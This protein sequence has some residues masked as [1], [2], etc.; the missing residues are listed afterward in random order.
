MAKPDVSARE[1]ALARLRLERMTAGEHLLLPPTAKE[2]ATAAAAAA[3][4]DDE[5]AAELAALG[6]EAAGCTRCKL[7]STRR[8]VVFGEGDAHAR[9]MF[10]GEGPGADEDASGHPF[11]GRAGKLLDRMIQAMGLAREEV[12][13]ANIV[14]CRP[15]G[16]RTPAP[17]E[18]AACSPYLC[19]QIR[20]IEPKVICALGSP[21]A[22]M[23]LATTAAIGKLRGRFHPIAF[24]RGSTKPL[25]MPTYH[26]AYLLRTP[27]DKPKVWEDLKQVLAEL[28]L[29][30]PER[31]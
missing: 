12:Y 30:V 20:I 23:L 28:G 3:G 7:A 31:K 19:E 14:K 15:P 10:V 11:V 16:N 4:A 27:G 13:I 22:K 26:P 21:A 8:H 6:A 2:A 24:G 29:P 18:V 1:Q 17:D 9:L 25:V 5:T